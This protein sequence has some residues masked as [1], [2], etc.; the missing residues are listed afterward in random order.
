MINV[1]AEFSKAFVKQ[2]KISLQICIKVN[3]FCVAIV[4][5]VKTYLKGQV[6]YSYSSRL[7]FV[8]MNLKITL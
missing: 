6:F 3:F 5:G 1:L 2:V 7:V 4:D 8:K